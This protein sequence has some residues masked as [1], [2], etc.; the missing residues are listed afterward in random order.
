MFA[1]SC[2]VAR[3]AALREGLARRGVDT[4]LVIFIGNDESPMNYRD[5]AYPFRQD[6]SF[7]YFFG[8]DLPNLAATMDLLTGE[9]MLFGDDVSMD[10]IVWTGPQPSVAELAARAGMAASRPRSALARAAEA[11]QATFRGSTRDAAPVAGL[12]YL[13]PY[14]AQTRIELAELAGLPL[15]AVAE[16]ASVPLIRE[17]VALRELK[18]AE[19]VAQIETAIGASVEMHRAALV[20]ARAGMLE[21]EIAARVGQVALASGGG[22]AFPTIATTKGATLHNH[23]YDLRLAE[24]GLFLLDA[25]AQAPSGYAGD[26]TTTFP[27]GP[28]FDARQREIYEIVLD[29]HRAAVALLA[30]KRPFREVHLAAAR[31]AACGLS[32]LGLMRGDPDQAVAAGAHALFFPHGIGHQIGLDVHDMENYGE[33]WVGYDGAPR[34]GQFGL[35]SLR[36]GKPLKAGMVHSVEPGLYFIPEL[37]AQWKADGRCAEYI[38]YGALGPYMAVGGVRYEEDW[39]VTEGGGRRLGP[40][41]D[42]SATAI[43][44]LRAGALGRGAGIA[45]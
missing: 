34:S 24:G 12:L 26:L 27:I 11:A 38:D 5:N 30:P 44:S 20:Y 43:E 10:D 16:G 45:G 1:A 6:S 42:R 35:A 7:L 37:I 4:G 3:R 23:G 8:L 13:P 36:L 28:R 29:M 39:L 14:R 32:A 33:S 17:A 18:S 40:E 41:F 2:Y 9:E 19:E 25:G 22:L 15:A 21:A 31:A